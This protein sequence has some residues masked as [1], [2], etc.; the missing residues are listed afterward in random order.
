MRPIQFRQPLW[1]KNNKFLRFHYWGFIGN[2]FVCPEW[3][4]MSSFQEAKEQSQQFIGLRDRNGKDIYEGDVCLLDILGNRSKGNP[5]KAFTVII[6]YKN[7]SFGFIHTHP[8]FV[9][10]ADRKWRSFWKDSEEEMWDQRYFEVI[11][12]IHENPEL[13]K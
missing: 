1:D 5:L 12:N 2:V 11:G 9:V 6:E 8:S 7:T 10:E 4:P 13:L 3:P